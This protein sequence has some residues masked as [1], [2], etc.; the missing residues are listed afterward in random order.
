MLVAGLP[1]AGKSRLLAGLPMGPDIAVLDS[2]AFRQALRPAMGGVPY[3][4]YRPLVHLMHRAAVLATAASPVRCVAVHLPATDP[5]HRV[6]VVALAGLTGR[7]A[8]LVWLDVDPEAARAGQRARGRLVPAASFARHVERAAAFEP[9]PGWA[10]VT[11]LD[12]ASA[13][14]LDLAVAQ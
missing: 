2:D 12:R 4:W 3:A 13:L 8:H 5:A 14:N 6:A 11:V 1:G 9:G 10:S 7:Q